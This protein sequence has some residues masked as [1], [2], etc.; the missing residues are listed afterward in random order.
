MSIYT[1]KFYVYMYLREDGTPYYIGKGKD[2]RAWTDFGRPCKIPSD[3][4]RI[5]LFMS[6]IDEAEALALEECL[7]IQYGRIDI[8]TGK[9]YN[10]TNGGEGISGYRH[11][12]ETKRRMSKSHTGVP[13]SQSHR[14]NI[15][16]ATVGENNPMHGRLHTDE[17]RAKMSAAHTGTTKSPET[18]SKMSAATSGE[19]NPM[20]GRRYKKTRDSIKR[21]ARAHMKCCEIDGVLYGSAKEAAKT[22]G[23]G[24]STVTARLK[25]DKFPEWNFV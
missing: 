15:Y 8:G 11:T 3:P 6:D 21:S 2:R 25:N 12:D 14:D 19:N 24:Y 18:R 5:V 22:L 23:V 10:K 13:K 7:I 20:Y 16:W 4:D 1:N 9:L 17:T